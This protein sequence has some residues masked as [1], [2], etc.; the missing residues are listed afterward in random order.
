[1]TFPEATTLQ[2][3]A[4]LRRRFFEDLNE[5]QREAYLATARKRLGVASPRNV[6][7]AVHSPMASRDV[8]IIE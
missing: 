8:V 7:A 6:P 4:E 2:R 5:S 3:E 1:M